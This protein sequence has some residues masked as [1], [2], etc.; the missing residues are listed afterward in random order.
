MAPISPE[1][2]LLLNRLLAEVD[3]LRQ[4]GVQLQREGEQYVKEGTFH[5]RIT[6]MSRDLDA[7]KERLDTMEKAIIANQESS[8]KRVIAVQAFIL[9][10]FVLAVIGYLIKL[11]IH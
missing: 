5:E 11:L 10:P 8:Y 3:Q 2:Q 6:G 1:L 4:G 9:S 7:L